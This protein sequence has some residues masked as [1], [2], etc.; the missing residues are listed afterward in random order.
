MV[1]LSRHIRVNFCG[2]NPQNLLKGSGQNTSKN[3]RTVIHRARGYIIYI[4]IK[5]EKSPQVAFL[6]FSHFSPSA[7]K[8]FR[9]SASDEDQPRQQQQPQRNISLACPTWWQKINRWKCFTRQISGRW[10]FFYIRFEPKLNNGRV[11]SFWLVCK[12]LRMW[13]KGVSACAS[14][15][16]VIRR[17]L[18]DGAVNENRDVCIYVCAGL[19]KINTNCAPASRFINRCW[20]SGPRYLQVRTAKDGPAA[21]YGW[22]AGRPAATRH[23]FRTRRKKL[24]GIPQ[25]VVLEKTL[26][27]SIYLAEDAAS[28]REHCCVREML[29]RREHLW[30]RGFS[31]EKPGRKQQKDFL[32]F[33]K[34]KCGGKYFCD[35]YIRTLFSVN[36]KPN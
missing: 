33:K 2:V 28:A 12:L 18:Y 11:C 29:Q 6:G 36:C 24:D 31:L 3:T 30:L 7:E 21:A 35:F 15:I 13:P 34:L 25:R 16:W 23:T 9:V 10:L 5:H 26:L 19:A 1:N 22:L 27:D 8:S 17:A 4:N 20:N 32:L 14:I